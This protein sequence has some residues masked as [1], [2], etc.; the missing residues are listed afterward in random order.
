M[1]LTLV[2]KEEGYRLTVEVEEGVDTATDFEAVVL[3]PTGNM[4]V[5]VRRDAFDVEGPVAAP[6]LAL[7]AHGPTMRFDVYFNSCRATMTAHGEVSATIEALPAPA[8]SGDA[9]SAAAFLRNVPVGASME[10]RRYAS[11]GEFRGL[12]SCMNKPALWADLEEFATLNA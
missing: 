11:S 12:R 5:I 1:Q 4:H 3:D 7:P 2:H 9:I 8:F 6:A 10:V